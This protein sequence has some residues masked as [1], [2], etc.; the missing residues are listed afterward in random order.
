MSDYNDSNKYTVASKP[1]VTFDDVIAYIDGCTTPSELNAMR[2]RVEAT[3]EALLEALGA[4][5]PKASRGSKD[6]P[7]LNGVEPP[8]IVGAE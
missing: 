7:A 8:R 4:P 2:D 1:A 5:K 6:K 3:R